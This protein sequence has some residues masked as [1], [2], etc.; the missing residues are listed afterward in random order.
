M[1]DDGLDALSSEKLH[2]LA[3][4]PY[5]RLFDVEFFSHIVETLPAAE[6]AS[7]TWTRPRPTSSS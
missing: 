6:A 3:V 4:S 7:A 2:D 5:K 1:S